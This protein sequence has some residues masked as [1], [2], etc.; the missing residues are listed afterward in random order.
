M[1]IKIAIILIEKLSIIA[2]YNDNEFRFMFFQI[3]I[4]YKSGIEYVEKKYN[5]G[6]VSIKKF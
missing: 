1:F 2:T 5:N 4:K 6:F 3:I